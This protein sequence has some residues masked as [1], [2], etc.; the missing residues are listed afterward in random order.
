M[1]ERRQTVD[2]RGDKLLMIFTEPEAQDFWLTPGDEFEIRALITDPKVNF[3]IAFHEEG[4][5]AYPPHK[6]GYI[7]VWCGN[8]ATV[9]LTK[10]THNHFNPYKQMPDA[11]RDAWVTDA[12]LDPLDALFDNRLRVYCSPDR[13]QAG[14]QRHDTPIDR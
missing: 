12:V 5:S 9:S 4:I 1:M 11:D 3:E 13:R 6:M 14:S 8:E 7:T 10:I 2:N